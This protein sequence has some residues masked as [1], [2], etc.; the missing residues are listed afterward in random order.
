MAV[1]VLV[2]AIIATSLVLLAS[3][4][5][6]S[7]WDRLASAPNWVA[8]ALGA[9][10]LALGGATGWAVWRLL[11]PAPKVQRGKSLPP[12]EESLI[13]RIEGAQSQGIDV[14]AATAE[15]EHWRQRRAAGEVYVAVF[16]DVSVGKSSLIAALV[17]DAEVR[18]H[19]LGGTTQR[20]TEYTWHSPG[21]D[22][23]ILVD[24]P[25]TNQVGGQWDQTARQEA[26][27]AHVVIYVC[28]GDLTRTQDAELAALSALQKPIILALTKTDR[29]SEEA[30]EL[31]RQRLRERVAERPSVELVTVQ[32][33][34]SERVARVHAD[35]RE[36]SVER[37]RPADVQALAEAL[38][39]RIDESVDAMASLRDSAVFLLVKQKLDE[40]EL[41]QRND[42]ADRLINEYTR[43][44][45]VG[46]L[47]AITPGTDI[48]IQGYFGANLVR[49]MCRL[50]G[51]APREVAVDEFLKL[52]QGE[53]R[54]TATVMLAVIGNG[55]KAFP[56]LGTVA[57]GLMH[58]V[59][60]G[61]TF[62]ALGRTLKSVLVTRGELRPYAAVNAFRETLHADL[63][64]SAGRFIEMALRAKKE[65]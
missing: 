64:H 1:L 18:T 48:L 38:Q 28:D 53:L 63:E 23:L 56:G 22:R 42:A 32:G 31:V 12:T 7:L 21:G 14:A 49:E 2:L 3:E 5:A 25:G 9:V 60:Y 51:V 10:L 47:A 35:G 59:A 29:Y 16:G 40:A 11:V 34:G 8:I 57:G 6:L 61:M 26:Q 52:A 58:A 41:R 65:R 37:E 27:R 50:Y 43:K 4:S 55:L 24:M 17:P 13:E 54:T 39:R 19:V 33:G 20:V 46:A 36:E 15:L 30:L 62:D 44:A 45:I